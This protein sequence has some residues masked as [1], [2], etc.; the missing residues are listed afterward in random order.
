MLMATEEIETLTYNN[1]FGQNE[2]GAHAQAKAVRAYLAANDGIEGSWSDDYK[3]YTAEPK[4]SRWENCREQGYVVWMRSA[5]HDRQINIAFY[6]HRNSDEIVALKWE[7]F[8]MNAPNIDGLP[9]GVFKSKYDTQH[10][11]SFGNAM[12]MADWVLEELTEFWKAT[13]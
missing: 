8:T 3:R 5:R 10:S 9:D 12:Q 7:Q 2:D 4:I 6:E 1:L 13:T 11:E